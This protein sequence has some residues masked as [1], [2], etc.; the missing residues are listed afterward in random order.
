MSAE[1][2]PNLSEA[3][4]LGLDLLPDVIE[5]QSPVSVED[6]AADGDVNMTSEGAPAAPPTDVP[7]IPEGSG[8]LGQ[9]G[10]PY[11]DDTRPKGSN[12]GTAPKLYV[13]F[14]MKGKS[15]PVV[16]DLILNV[17]NDVAAAQ[18]SA[19]IYNNMVQFLNQM[20]QQQQAAKGI[21]PVNRSLTDDE[22]RRLASQLAEVKGTSPGGIVLP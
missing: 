10:S 18:L 17:Q 3:E 19:V 12:G 21:V 8:Q 6:G 5:E 15:K 16:P 1:N 4:A 13:R 7:A 14:L 20:M 2:M 9:Q 22:L 11:R